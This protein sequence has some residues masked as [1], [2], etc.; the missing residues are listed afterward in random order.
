MPKSIYRGSFSRRAA[1]TADAA[2][3]GPAAEE[4][5][6]EGRRGIPIIIRIFRESA[7]GS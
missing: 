6:R 3:L 1:R 7:I 2:E 4:E 5:R